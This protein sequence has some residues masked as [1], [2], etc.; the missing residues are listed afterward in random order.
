MLKVQGLPFS[1]PYT[2]REINMAT[3]FYVAN[4]DIFNKNQD[5]YW[6]YLSVQ[7]YFNGMYESN[8]DESF[9]DIELDFL[10]YNWANGEIFVTRINEDYQIWEV[11]KKYKLGTRVLSVDARLISEDSNSDNQIYSFINNVHGVYT[12]WSTSGLSSWYFW[13]RPLQKL[14]KMLTSFEVSTDFDAKKMFR[15]FTHTNKLIMAKEKYAMQDPTNPYIDIYQKDEQQT[16]AEATAKSEEV[17][18]MPTIYKEITADSKSNQIFENIQNYYSFIQRV[19]GVATPQEFKASR[20]NSL[21]SS[22]DIYDT[23]NKED[24]T[25]RQLKKFSREAK[26]LWNVDIRWEKNFKLEEA[27]EDKKGV[28]NQNG[29]DLSNN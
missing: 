1:V 18:V 7:A 15:I 5:V 26:K 23:V 19:N 25:L 12:K 6:L 8:G 3:N 13:W 20:K 16:S 28:D 21:E 2:A 27:T 17:K 10:K 29:S 14:A 22:T 9:K 4:I 24:I 11:V